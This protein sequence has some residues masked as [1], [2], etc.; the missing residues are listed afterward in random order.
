[1][2][3]QCVH[4]AAVGLGVAE[5]V[6]VDSAGIVVQL[7][8]AVLWNVHWR[9]I[10]LMA[11]A[12]QQLCTVQS[13]APFYAVDSAL[14]ALAAD[15]ELWVPDNDSSQLANW[16]LCCNPQFCRYHWQFCKCCQLALC[17]QAAAAWVAMQNCIY[18][19]FSQFLKLFF[20]KMKN[21]LLL[22]TLWLLVFGLHSHA[23]ALDLH[24]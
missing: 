15:T 5:A 11:L 23:H 2:A 3:L 14:Q 12:V 7:V 19:F 6:A 1:M 20:S 22:Q 17:W 8:V 24:C 21:S 16:V 9:R 10:E 4:V 13:S 18:S